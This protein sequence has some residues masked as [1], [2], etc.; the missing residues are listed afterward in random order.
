M[1]I[2]RWMLLGMALAMVVPA[3]AADA[4]ATRQTASFRWTTTSPSAPT[5]YS[6][7]VDIDDPSNAEAKPHSL[8]ELVLEFPRGTVTDTTTLP[9][10]NA[11]DAELML[12]GAAACPSDT[13]IGDG[14]IVTDTGSTQSG[15][16]R[17]VTNDVTQFNHQDEVIGFAQSRTDPPVRAVSRSK[18]S[19]TTST[20][21]LPPF[22]TPSGPE[23]FTAFRQI[24]LSAP[25]I[26]HN[27]RAYARTP[28]SCPESGSWLI[29]ITFSYWDGVSQTVRTHTPCR[30]GA[31]GSSRTTA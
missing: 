7:A 16:P 8:R 5:G 2:A 11:T 24:R 20:S 21:E 3:D 28:A 30:R 18:L 23:P 1:H 25:A 10:C 4:S 13:R 17:L 6:M 29:T 14:T 27:G 19:G 9:Q 31:A 12:E 15:F 22:P 26:V